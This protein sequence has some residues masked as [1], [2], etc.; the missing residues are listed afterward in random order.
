V[1]WFSTRGGGPPTSKGLSLF[2]LR[3][4]PLADMRFDVAIDTVEPL[5][6]KNNLLNGGLRPDLKLRGTGRVPRLLGPVYLNTT[7]VSLPAADLRLDSGV[8]DFRVDDFLGPHLEIVGESNIAGYTVQVQVTGPL[9]RFEVLLSSTPSL[10]QDELVTLLATG[11]LPKGSLGRT[12][13]EDAATTTA[14]YLAKD[15]LRRWLGDESTD[16]GESLADRVSVFSGGEVSRSGGQ[17]V[18]VSLRLSDRE[19]KLPVTLITGE[20]DAFDEI[21]LGLRFLFRL[22]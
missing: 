17:T 20:R 1:N 15:A 4:A 3:S 6:L 12:T 21:N 19:K 2:S 7:R 16:S 18:E 13:A 22:P 9:D 8:I 11:Q 5:V 10:R 14:Y